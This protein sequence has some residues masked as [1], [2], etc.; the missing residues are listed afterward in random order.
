MINYLRSTFWCIRNGIDAALSARR[1]TDRGTDLEHMVRFLHNSELRGRYPGHVRGN[2]RVV[3]APGFFRRAGRFHGFAV[4]RTILLVSEESLKDEGLVM[5]E[6][7]HVWQWQHEPLCMILAYLHSYDN[8]YEA[9]AR[10]MADAWTGTTEHADRWA[11][12]Q[13]RSK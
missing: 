10:A 5:H 7:T 2:Y 3:I 6:L 13:R 11:A 1:G 12:R 9:Q 4:G 8:E